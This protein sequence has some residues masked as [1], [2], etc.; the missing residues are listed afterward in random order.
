M[1]PFGGV[2]EMDPQIC[3]D[4]EQRRRLAAG[5]AG[6]IGGEANSGG[7]MDRAGSIL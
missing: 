7:K 1:E 6:W 2:E 4:E 3:A 5:R